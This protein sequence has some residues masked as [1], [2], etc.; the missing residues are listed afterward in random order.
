[1]RSWAET[2]ADR[3]NWGAGSEMVLSG[4][5]AGTTGKRRETTTR[6]RLGHVTPPL[7]GTAKM[8]KE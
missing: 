1:M 6:V 3:C 8:P 4:G 5:L 7:N 2:R